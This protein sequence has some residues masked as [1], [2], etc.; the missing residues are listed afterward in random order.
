[1]I[2]SLVS[3]IIN[4]LLIFNNVVIFSSILSLIF[5]YTKDKN[6]YIV[7]SAI[8]GILYDI[9]CFKGYIHIL[10]FPLI[11]LIIMYYFKEKKYNY[12]NVLILSM[13]IIFLYNTFVFLLLKILFISTYS[14][15]YFLTNLI[16]IYIVNI[17]YV[18][19]LYLLIKRK[20]KHIIKW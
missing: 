16:F 9:I 14:Y 18:S 20:N 15:T 19:L 3:T 11:S 4:P 13:F 12:K 7:K 5:M 1:M 6:E 2:L 8:I 17:I 10:L